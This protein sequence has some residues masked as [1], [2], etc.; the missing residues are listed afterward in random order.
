MFSI[1]FLPIYHRVNARKAGRNKVQSAKSFAAETLLNVVHKLA[2]DGF[3]R[4][5]AEGGASRRLVTHFAVFGQ[6]RLSENGVEDVIL[7]PNAQFGGQIR[8]GLVDI[9]GLHQ[10]ISGPV[11]GHTLQRHLRVRV[12]VSIVLAHADQLGD[13]GRIVGRFPP[14]RRQEVGETLRRET[15]D[16]MNGVAIATKRVDRDSSARRHLHLGDLKH[17]VMGQR[18]RRNGRHFRPVKGIV[19]VG[20]ADVE[21]VRT[22]RIRWSGSD[23]NKGRCCC[24]VGH[25]RLPY[26]HQL[27]TDVL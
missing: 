21:D 9:S 27:F 23:E 11:L 17:L 3:H 14:L 5:D 4:V 26:F 10:I 13:V 8:S 18:A 25:H 20:D 19:R 22:G 12:I 16:V 15:I 1:L 7:G 6:N 2:P 24:G